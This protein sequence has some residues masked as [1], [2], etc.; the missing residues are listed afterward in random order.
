MHVP[1]TLREARDLPAGSALA[2]TALGDLVVDHYVNLAD[3]EL[4]AFNAAVTDWERVRGFER[5]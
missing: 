1:A 3:V 2:R 4:A 5:M